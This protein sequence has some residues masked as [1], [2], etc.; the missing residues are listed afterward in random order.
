MQKKYRAH[1]ICAIGGL[2]VTREFRELTDGYAKTNFSGPLKTASSLAKAVKLS[3]RGAGLKKGLEKPFDIITTESEHIKSHDL[4]IIVYLVSKRKIFDIQ[5]FDQLASRLESQCTDLFKSL[6]LSRACQSG[7]MPLIEHMDISVTEDSQMFIKE[8]NKHF[9]A[10]AVLNLLDAKQDSQFLKTYL[11]A[12]IQK[13]RHQAACEPVILT[14]KIVSFK[15]HNCAIFMTEKNLEKMELIISPEFDLSKLIM[16]WQF[17]TH[18]VIEAVYIKQAPSQQNNRG[19][20]RFVDLLQA[21]EFDMDGALG[22]FEKAAA[23]LQEKSVS[24]EEWL[25]FKT[26]I[27]IEPEIPLSSSFSQKKSTDVDDH[28]ED[29]VISNGAE[30]TLENDEHKESPSVDKPKTRKR[31]AR[32]SISLDDFQT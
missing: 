23:Y 6:I 3:I 10:S 8:F 31:K 29:F 20:F 12:V 24:A 17:H 2:L 14:G 19:K 25:T 16:L 15:D 11:A 7:Q 22:M 13:A 28:G 9:K 4:G 30:T 32:K 18:C 27:K 26:A 1:N 5:K 21:H